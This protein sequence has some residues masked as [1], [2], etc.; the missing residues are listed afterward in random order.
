MERPKHY[1]SK[2]I[3]D[4]TPDECSILDEI[5]SKNK[6]HELFNFTNEGDKVLEI[7]K[8]MYPGLW[9]AFRIGMKRARIQQFKE[10]DK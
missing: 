10:K 4:L 5:E 9:Q 2:Q 1:I 3:P 8:D 7:M 6:E